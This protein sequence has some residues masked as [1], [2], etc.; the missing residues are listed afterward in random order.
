MHKQKC[1]S[2]NKSVDI[3]QQHVTT[4]RYQDAFSSFVTAY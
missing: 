2:D 1:N 3:L 4:S